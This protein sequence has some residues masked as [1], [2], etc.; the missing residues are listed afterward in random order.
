MKTYLHLKTKIQ[1]HILVIPKKHISSVANTKE[2]DLLLMGKLIMSAKKIAEDLKISNKGYKL[3]VR[4]GRGGGQEID[5]I[6]LHLLGGAKLTE[7][8]HPI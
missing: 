6:H 8:I 5:H 4:V 2:S 7:N 1:L 3:L